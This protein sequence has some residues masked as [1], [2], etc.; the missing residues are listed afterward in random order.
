MECYP[1]ST[2]VSCINQ[3]YGAIR[4]VKR[5]RKRKRISNSDVWLLVCLCFH[6]LLLPDTPGFD[7]KTKVYTNAQS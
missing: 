2:L 5:K 1:H 3:K 4:L 7:T 6:N